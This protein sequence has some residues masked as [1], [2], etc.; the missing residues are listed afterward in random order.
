MHKD[1]VRYIIKII[2]K[3]LDTIEFWSYSLELV[4]VE[5]IEERDI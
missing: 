3:G 4:I 1:G 2:A 5:V